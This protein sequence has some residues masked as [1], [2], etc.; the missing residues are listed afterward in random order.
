MGEIENKLVLSHI[1]FRDSEVKSY[2]IYGYGIIGRMLKKVLE[3][4][5]QRVVCFVCSD[6][7]KT[8]EVVEELKVYELN[9]YLENVGGKCDVLM[10]VQKGG[11]QVLKILSEL[12]LSVTMLNSSQDYNKLY[13]YF[14]KHYFT[15]NGVDITRKK[16]LLNGA[17]F[18]NPFTTDIEY[19][20]PFFS[21]CGDL[22]LPALY[23]DLGC[24]YEGPYEVGD[25]KIEKNDIVFDCGSNIGLFSIVAAN[26]CKKVYAFEPV[27]N[28][29]KYI[30]DAVCD[31]SN[32]ELC[33]YALSDYNGKAM[34]SIGENESYCNHL[35]GENNNL[36]K[37]NMLEVNIITIDDFVKKYNIERVDYIKADIE[38]EER[39]MLRGAKDTLKKF[40]PKLSICEYH[41][42][43]DPE[44]LEQIILEANPKYIIRHNY[45]KLYAYVPSE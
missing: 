36:K 11:Q 4:L 41:L 7:Y 20:L 15:R 44:V 14:Y 33:E 38:G 29:Q 24:I 17:K 31:V 27:P 18:L 8:E 16:L 43:D 45:M 34:F 5:K 12:D 25:V 1:V 6:G 35:V 39:N 23:Q 28:A 30:K 42:P 19:A 21:E 2:A 3:L 26:K 40:A 13:G 10:T 22:I 9:E 32:I 37:E